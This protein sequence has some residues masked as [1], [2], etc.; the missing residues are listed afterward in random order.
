MYVCMYVSYHVCMYCIFLPLPHPH[1]LP[2]SI[3]RRPQSFLK[4]ADNILHPSDAIFNGADNKTFI[5]GC[6]GGEGGGKGG[7]ADDEMSQQTGYVPC[8]LF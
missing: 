5:E 8:F 6:R 4:D 3:T 7:S 1:P 2:I